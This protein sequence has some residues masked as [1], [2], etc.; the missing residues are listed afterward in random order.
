MIFRFSG[1]QNER[2][3]AASIAGD[4]AGVQAAL[5][6][7]AD[8][9]TRFEKRMTPLYFAAIAGSNEAVRNCRP[10][11]EDPKL[12]PHCC[13]LAEHH[14]DGLIPPEGAHPQCDRVR[15]MATAVVTSRLVRSEIIAPGACL[16]GQ[17]SHCQS[18]LLV[19]SSLWL[20][21]SV[22]E[23]NAI[24]GH[25]LHKPSAANNAG[26]GLG[27]IGRERDGPDGGAV[28]AAARCVLCGHAD[29]ARQLLIEGAD[30]YPA[31]A[32]G[33]WTALHMAAL[34]GHTLVVDVCRPTLSAFLCCCAFPCFRPFSMRG[35]VQEQAAP[36]VCLHCMMCVYHISSSIFVPGR[37]CWRGTAQQTVQ[38]AV[39]R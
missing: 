34:H 35:K 28:D 33:G 8:P 21:L 38:H 5:T 29:V 17:G 3:R 15:T 31:I 11:K 12:R 39:R 36:H 27:S 20:R 26:A 37:C 23:K 13:V 7:G 25:K 14:A 2:L 6:D 30:P 24:V 4:A 9:A 22:L 1:L 18:L 19:S 10:D 16:L 32:N